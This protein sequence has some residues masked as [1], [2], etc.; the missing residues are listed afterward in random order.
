MKVDSEDSNAD[1]GDSNADSE[2]SNADSEDS[3]ADSEDS[4]AD[5][6]DSNADSKDSNAYSWDISGILEEAGL[7]NPT[8]SC[9]FLI[10]LYQLNALSQDGDKSF[11]D[12]R[13]L[14]NTPHSVLHMRSRLMLHDVLA[15]SA[16]MSIEYPRDFST[17]HLIILTYAI[18]ISS[19]F[20]LTSVLFVSA[21]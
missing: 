11:I 12:V 8:V 15:T 4:N 17:M 21:L 19:Y 13:T 20:L 5:S 10:S 16:G 9:P 2:D 7:L 1:S 14:I 3:N 18:I 6:E